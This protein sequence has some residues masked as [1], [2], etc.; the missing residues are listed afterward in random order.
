M[1]MYPENHKVQKDQVNKKVQNQKKLN[2][3]KT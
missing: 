1:T 3:M 2:L